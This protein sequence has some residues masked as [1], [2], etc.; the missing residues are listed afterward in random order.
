MPNGVIAPPGVTMGSCGREDK[1][2]GCENGGTQLGR[3]LWRG[4]RAR[5]GGFCRDE[6]ESLYT[7]PKH[8]SSEA[9]QK[10]PREMRYRLSQLRV[11]TCG[12]DRRRPGQ[13]ACEIYTGDESSG[14]AARMDFGA[15]TKACWSFEL[16]AFAWRREDQYQ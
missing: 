14:K 10:T 5:F 8:R 15:A 7:L 1:K 2:T 9:L 12:S 13:A 4:A 3:V 11:N 6:V 16:E